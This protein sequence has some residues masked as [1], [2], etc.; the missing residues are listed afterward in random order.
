MF[1]FIQ[2]DIII[3]ANKLFFKYFR[4]FHLRSIHFSSISAHFEF[5]CGR[6]KKN[7]IHEGESHHLIE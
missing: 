2:F 5:Q 7:D 1:H 4:F 3:A 6:L